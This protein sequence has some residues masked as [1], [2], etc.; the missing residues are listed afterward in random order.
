MAKR[1]RFDIDDAGADASLRRLAAL[2]DP[3]A[4]LVADGLELEEWLED[5][6]REVRCLPES[7]RR[8]LKPEALYCWDAPRRWERLRV[9]EWYSRAQTGL[10]ER[11]TL[12]SRYDAEDNA[13]ITLSSAMGV[14]HDYR[15]ALREG[16]R[17][18]YPD[19]AS[20]PP[21]MLEQIARIATPEPA[22]GLAVPRAHVG[23]CLELS[24]IT[25]AAST[26]PEAIPNHH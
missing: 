1:L 21:R 2:A 26:T 16:L 3:R 7:L 9:Q 10:L 13:P 5:V 14:T 24:I 19:Q 12:I 4:H 23:E 17:A 8:S 11:L 25:T 20:V 18:L 22:I 6:L 15:H